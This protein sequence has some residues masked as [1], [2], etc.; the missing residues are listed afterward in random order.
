[1]VLL[2]NLDPLIRLCNGT[3]LI[4]ERFGSKMVQA[5]ILTGRNISQTVT[6]P[7]VDLTS[8]ARDSSFALKKRQFS[9]ELG[10]PMTINKSQ[11]QTLQCVGVYLPKPVFSHG[12][13]YVAISRVTSP[14]G[15]KF[16]ICN[17]RDVPYNVTK[18]ILYWEIFNDIPDTWLVS[19]QINFAVVVTHLHSIH[20]FYNYNVK[21]IM[22]LHKYFVP[23]VYYYRDGRSNT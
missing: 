9:L 19:F 18:N 6:I 3:H 5:K 16:L 15:L 21:Y 20:Y 8:S 23:F 7:R 1:M 13:L 17:K 22:S 2:R 14:L 11:G 12:Q 10:F 4:I